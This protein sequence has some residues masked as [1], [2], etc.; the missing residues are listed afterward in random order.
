MTD[1]ASIDLRPISRH[2]DDPPLLAAVLRPYRANCKYLQSAEV[3]ADGEPG[4]GGR[5][6]ARCTFTIPESCYIDDTGHFNSVEFNIC[7]NQMLYYTVAKSVQERLVQPF[8]RWSMDDYWARQLADFLI[9][10]FRSSFKRAMSGRHFHGELEMVDIAEWGG[11]DVRDPLIVVRTTCRY[12]DDR[13][14]TS[15]GEVRV[16]I[17]NPPVGGPEKT[18]T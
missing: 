2:A 3:T 17:T 7:Y 6:T 1:T 12:W 15:Q 16:A 13:G 11:S 4:D 9:T 5:V 14:G 8:A 10:D 18:G